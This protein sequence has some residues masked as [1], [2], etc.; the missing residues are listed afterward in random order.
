MCSTGH[1][2][3]CDMGA[4][5]LVGLQA[6]LGVVTL[7]FAAPLALSLILV[8]D[9]MRSFRTISDGLTQIRQ[10]FTIIGDRVDLN[11]YATMAGLY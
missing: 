8:L 9:G 10:L 5:L 1:Q 2:S 11:L 6:V 4:N 7:I 3:L